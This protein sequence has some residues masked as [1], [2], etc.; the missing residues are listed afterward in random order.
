LVY[1][2]DFADTLSRWT[3]E[4]IWRK[5]SLTS[6]NL[7]LA[8]LKEAEGEPKIKKWTMKFHEKRANELIGVLQMLGYLKLDLH[9]EEHSSKGS[10]PN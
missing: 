8:F 6:D 2:F 3:V 1:I 9:M 4:R 7:D 10:I 5:G